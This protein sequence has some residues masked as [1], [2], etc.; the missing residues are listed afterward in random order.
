MPQRGDIRSVPYP[1][2]LTVA[3]IARALRTLPWA[4]VLEPAIALAEDGFA[5]SLILAFASHLI[6]EVPGAGQL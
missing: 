2:R 6:A 5:A 1:A 3:R 4:T